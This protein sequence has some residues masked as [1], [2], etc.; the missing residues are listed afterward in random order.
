MVTFYYFINIWPIKVNGNADL[1]YCPFERVYWLAEID[2]IKSQIRVWWL[3][4]SI[5]FGSS[6]MR[7]N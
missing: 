4:T 5:V 3:E 6:P 7:V 2:Q 1:F